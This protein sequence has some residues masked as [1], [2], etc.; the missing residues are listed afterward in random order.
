LALLHF[1][2]TKKELPLVALFCF[3][4]D[5]NAAKGFTLLSGAKNQQRK[6]LLSLNNKIREL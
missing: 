1:L 6:K 3:K 5:I 2:K 4:N